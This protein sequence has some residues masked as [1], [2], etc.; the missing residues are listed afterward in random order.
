MPAPSPIAMFMAVAS[1]WG[2]WAA[3]ALSLVGFLA[4]QS[5]IQ[6]QAIEAKLDEHMASQG[7]SVAI[8]QIMCTAVVSTDA[9]REACRQAGEK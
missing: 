5:V 8:L 9:E 7:R 1:K 6:V 3:L 2:P 4:W